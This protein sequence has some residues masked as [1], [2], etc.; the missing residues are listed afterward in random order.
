MK[1]IFYL[2]FFSYSLDYLPPAPTS[3]YQVKVTL[4]EMSDI[5]ELLTLGLNSNGYITNN[6]YWIKKLSVK[7]LSILKSSHFDYE[8][9]KEETTTF[10]LDTF[11]SFLT[12]GVKAEVN[13]LGCSLDIYYVQ[14]LRLSFL[15]IR[16]LDLEGKQYKFSPGYNIPKGEYDYH[17]N[18]QQLPNGIYLVQL[19][20]MNNGPNNKTREKI[21]TF[22]TKQEIP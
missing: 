4:V 10:N 1:Y 19:E 7:E 17:W 15:G 8:I 12:G 20:S 21:A 13:D 5:K 22:F 9:M 18:T 11:S 6:K 2:L 16:I 14:S 3:S